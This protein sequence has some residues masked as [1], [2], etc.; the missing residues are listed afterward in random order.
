VKDA[1]I[2]KAASRMR[3]FFIAIP[4]TIKPNTP[5]ILGAGPRAN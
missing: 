4:P 2:S 1:T 5:A 3:P